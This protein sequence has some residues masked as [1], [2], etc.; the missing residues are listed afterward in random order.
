VELP[1]V[2]GA[3]DVVAIEVPVA[4]RPAGMIA[5]AGDGA[6]APVVKAQG[7]LRAADRDLVQRPLPE[8]LDLTEVVP[9]FL[10]RTLL[11]SRPRQRVS[12]CTAS[13][14]RRI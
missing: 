7:D 5:G 12:Y 4:E 10:H 8:L 14:R 3:D 9:T 1:V 2:P 11:R 6:E 13:P